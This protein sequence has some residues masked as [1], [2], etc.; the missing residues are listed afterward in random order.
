MQIRGIK[1][2]QQVTESRSRQT[3]ARAELGDGAR[4]SRP[5]DGAQEGGEPRARQPET[6]RKTRRD[7]G[8]EEAV[9][10]DVAEDERFTQTDGERLQVADQRTERRIRQ[11]DGIEQAGKGPAPTG[12]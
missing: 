10:G 2:A 6:E 1:Q 9:V 12:G 8:A 5:D 11:N 3:G 7:L 4:D